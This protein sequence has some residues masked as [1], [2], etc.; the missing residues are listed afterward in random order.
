MMTRLG[1]VTMSEFTSSGATLAQWLEQWGLRE[2]PFAAWNADQDLDLPGYFVD[3]GHF[4]DLLHL[5]EPCVV[6]AR[7]GCGKTAQR[8]M[9][10]A[11]CRPLNPDSPWLAVTYAYSGLESALAAAEHD[12]TRLKDTHHASALLRQALVALEHEAKH[13]PAVRFA[14]TQPNVAPQFNG[15]VSRFAPH[16]ATH[17]VAGG[18]DGLEGLTTLEFMQG[19]VDLLTA[20]KLERCVFLVDGL[21]EFLLTAVDSAQ[22]VALLAP[23]LCTLP[24]LEC[25]GLAFKFFLPQEIEP[26]LRECRWFRTD[27]LRTFRIRWEEG[28]LGRL[29]G[30]RL[31]YFSRKGDR[32]YT[33]LGQFCRDELADSIDRELAGLAG[34]L[35]RAALILADMLLRTHCEQPH[36]P[37]R[38][39]LET[40]IRVKEEWEDVRRGLPM[41]TLPD[42]LS[43]GVL[44]KGQE[45]LV[46]E[47]PSSTV[48]S[49]AL[50]VDEETGRVWLGEHE[51]T[52]EINPQDFRVLTCLYRRQGDVCGKDILVKEAWP[53]DAAEGVTDGS[54]TQSIARLRKNLGQSQPYTRYIETIR[55]R[56]YRLHPEGFVT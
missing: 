48:G 50:V 6:F 45:P 51:I 44:T 55:G 9:L 33:R 15:Y 16:L 32:A 56:G 34:G 4:D 37:E 17:P 19:F 41:A 21:D 10:A 13:D 40:W 53:G 12:A 1:K 28:D 24:L 18:A 7:R 23:L 46:T 31:T 29:I 49:A 14:L 30:Q 43:E 8:Q 27:R 36:P 38:I 2:N 52:S 5:A 54:I 39:A 20:A 47:R 42:Q 22:L 35:P 11:Q 25:P 26:D 3:M